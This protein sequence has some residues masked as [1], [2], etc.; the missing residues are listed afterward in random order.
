MEYQKMIER[1]AN[2]NSLKYSKLKAI[3][4]LNELSAALT[5]SLTK[6]NQNN[7]ED[8]IEEFGDVL[9]RLDILKCYY[10]AD[11]ITARSHKK[12]SKSIGYI[13]QKKYKNV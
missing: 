7:D 13:E 12:V 1:I 8:I 6:K 5:Q 4:E 3:E 2:N 10:D 9:F 11:K